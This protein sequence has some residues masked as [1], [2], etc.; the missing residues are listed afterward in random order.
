MRVWRRLG[1][2]K[3]GSTKG[4]QTPEDLLLSYESEK[5]ERKAYLEELRKAKLE[6]ARQRGRARAQG[7]GRAGAQGVL[8]NLV[9]GTPR[10][11]T[12]KD[13]SVPLWL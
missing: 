11:K 7:R 3:E 2:W 9:Y 10:K 12:G 4:W 1:K 5:A 6:L 13:R 8:H